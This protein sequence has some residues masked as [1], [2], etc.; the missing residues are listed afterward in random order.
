M[1]CN[2]LI[3]IIDRQNYIF[4]LLE[5]PL[6]PRFLGRTENKE[7]TP[8]KYLSNIRCSSIRANFEFQWINKFLGDSFFGPGIY[9]ERFRYFFS[10]DFLRLWFKNNKFIYYV[11]F[12]DEYGNRPTARSSGKTSKAAAEAWAAE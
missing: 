3:K 7:S 4:S 6:R 2:T 11:Q 8:S 5:I 12:Y 9:K 1:H 10:T